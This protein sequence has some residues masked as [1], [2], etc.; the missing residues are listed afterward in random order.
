MPGI[1]TKC[2]YR[3]LCILGKSIVAKQ[4]ACLDVLWLLLEVIRLISCEL[5]S[6]P[7]PAGLA[8]LRKWHRPAASVTKS[9]SRRKFRCGP[10]ASEIETEK[11][12]ITGPDPHIRGMHLELTEALIREVSAAIGND[13]YPLSPRV[14]L[15]RSILHQ[16]RPEPV[17]EPLPP[18]KSYE[19]PS[20]G[21]Y[22]RRR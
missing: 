7:H 3:S 10:F 16:L 6:H 12:S 15:L 22:G 4:A 14:Q 21:K 19:P 1:R 11:L 9:W 17:R 2:F 13:R 8:Y 5:G 20:R 18:R